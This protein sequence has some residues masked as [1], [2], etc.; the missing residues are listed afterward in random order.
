MTTSMADS[1][2]TGFPDGT[3]RFLRG[4]ARDNSKQ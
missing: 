2:F 4:I 3:F 1:E